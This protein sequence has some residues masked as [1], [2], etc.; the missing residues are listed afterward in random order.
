MPIID[1]NSP[2][3][4]TKDHNYLVIVFG[5][6]RIQDPKD[7]YRS[8]LVFT[9][10]LWATCNQA[11]LEVLVMTLQNKNPVPQYKIIKIQDIIK[12]TPRF[13]FETEQ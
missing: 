3:K 6:R 5:D 12:A 4:L 13:V 10:E 8:E 2:E 7:D 9:P 1:I 11:E